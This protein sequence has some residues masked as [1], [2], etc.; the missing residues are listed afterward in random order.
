MAST[1]RMTLKNVAQCPLF[2]KAPGEEFLVVSKDGEPVD[3]HWRKRIA[4]GS[5]VV[6]PDAPDPAAEP[7]SRAVSSKTAKQKD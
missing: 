6:I 4:D 7:V 5:V 2:G 1:E 3:L